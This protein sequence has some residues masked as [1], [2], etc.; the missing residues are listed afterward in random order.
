MCVIVHQGLPEVFGCY[1]LVPFQECIH[2]FFLRGG[3]EV[4]QMQLAIL[5]EYLDI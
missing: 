4:C 1:F 2:D 5:A 3:K